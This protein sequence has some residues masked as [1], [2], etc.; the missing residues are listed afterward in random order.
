MLA[1]NRFRRVV[2]QTEK[3]VEITRD[4][5]MRHSS[6]IFVLCAVCWDLRAAATTVIMHNLVPNGIGLKDMSGNLLTAGT[7][8]AG[9]GAI[10]QLGYYSAATAADP[11]AGAWIV[12]AGSDT[13]GDKSGDLSAGKFSLSYQFKDDYKFIP[14]A[15]TPLAI[16]FYDSTSLATANYFNCVSNTNGTW[17]WA[18]GTPEPTITLTFST[19]SPTQVWQGGAASAFRTTLAVPEPS[20]VLL[21]MIGLGPLAG[22]RRRR[23]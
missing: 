6:A 19:T 22:M 9:D 14:V 1:A 5:A 12:M 23:E 11:F 7:A 20:G 4:L 8:S 21:A 2:H 17:N 16:R 15:G 13:I 3:G 18:G 10:L